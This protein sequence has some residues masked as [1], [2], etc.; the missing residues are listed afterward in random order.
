MDAPT[1][2]NYSSLTID[3]VIA[4]PKCRMRV[5]HRI[6]ASTEHRALEVKTI[7]TW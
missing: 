7:L 4:N 5:R 3:L 2:Q 1:N 6:I